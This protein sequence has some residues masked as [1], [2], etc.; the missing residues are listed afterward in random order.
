MDEVIC[1]FLGPLCRQY[2]ELHG[3]DRSPDRF[4]EYDLSSF[5]G[6]KGREIFLKAGFFYSLEPYPGSLEI[7]ETLRKDGHD[8]IIASNALGNP[9]AAADKCRWMEKYL[10]ALLA[11]NFFITSRKY[12]IRGDIL[13]D[14]SPGVLENFPGIRVVMDRPYNQQVEGFR[15]YNNNWHDFYRLVKEQSRK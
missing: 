4:S 1:D 8:V 15:I 9:D 2:N 14:D 12:L 7:I 13:F 3:T 6:G 10:P 11:E 5:I